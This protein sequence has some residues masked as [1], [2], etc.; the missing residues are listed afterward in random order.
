MFIHEAPKNDE[1]IIVSLN[2]IK[3]HQGKIHLTWLRYQLAV[4]PAKHKPLEG[5]SLHFS[6]NQPVEVLPSLHWLWRDH[7]GLAAA[8]IPDSEMSEGR[9]ILTHSSVSSPICKSYD[10]NAFV[11]NHI[12]LQV[13]KFHVIVPLWTIRHTSCQLNVFCKGA[14]QQLL[15]KSSVLTQVTVSKGI[16]TLPWF[17]CS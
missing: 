17:E 12:S 3:L 10:E 1:E 9:Q 7:G 8:Q 16:I 14:Q 11:I 15:Q 13:V 5:H 4:I 6:T 2:T